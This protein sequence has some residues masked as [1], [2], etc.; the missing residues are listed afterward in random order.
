MSRRRSDDRAAQSGPVD[1]AGDS[2]LAAAVCGSGSADGSTTQ[3]AYHAL[4]RLIVRGEIAPGTKLKIDGLRSRLGTGASPI[5]AAL[6]L[7]TSD[8]LVERI[9]QRG[10]CVA[11]VG[12][13]NFEEILRLRCTLEDTALRL[14]IARMDEARE[15]DLVLMHHRMLRRAGG[16]TEAFEQAHKAFHMALLASCNAPILLKLCSQLYD[17]NIRYRYI[18]GRSLGYRTRNVTDEHRDILDAVI[19]R[20]PDLAAGRLLAHYRQTGAFLAGLFEDGPL[21]S[22]G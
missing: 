12:Q 5:R 20:E 7:L 4:R 2:D 1:P 10:F 16:E 18:A 17:L 11:P 13:K 9:D 8:N 19:A 6:S 21:L 14:S 3:R 15:E 22:T